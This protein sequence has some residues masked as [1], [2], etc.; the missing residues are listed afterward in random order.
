[1]EPRT[2]SRPDPPSL[3]PAEW[4]VMKVFWEHGNLAARDA[5][6]LLPSELGWAYPTL[7][8]LLSRLVAKGALGY[9]QVGNSYLYEP[10][11]SRESCTVRELEEFTDRVFDGKPIPVLSRFLEATELSQDEIERLRALL[12]EKERSLASTGDREGEA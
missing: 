7:K 8:T 12:E 10:E 4:Q 3:S 9:V 11:V 5:F 6:A 2:P 1:M